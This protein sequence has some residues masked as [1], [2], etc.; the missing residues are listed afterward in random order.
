MHYMHMSAAELTKLTETAVEAGLLTKEWGHA[1][2]YAGH[3]YQ[4]IETN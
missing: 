2:N 1:Y 4:T 3:I